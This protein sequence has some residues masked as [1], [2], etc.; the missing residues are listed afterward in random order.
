MA[1]IVVADNDPDALDLVLTDL[2]LEGHEVYGA[3]DAAAATALVERVGPHVV[4]LDYWMPPGDDGLELAERLLARRPQ[5]RVVI[6]SNY[7][8]AALSS[9]AE[10]IGVPFL[11]KGNLRALRA[12]VAER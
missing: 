2:R 11:A 3:G 4:V 9:R 7:R 5:L 12:S 1:R 6:Y 8:R 10:A